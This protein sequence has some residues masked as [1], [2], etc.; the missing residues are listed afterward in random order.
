MENVRNGG[1]IGEKELLAV[2][3]GTSYA[4]NRRRTIGAIEEA[5]EQAFS[6]WSIRRAFTSK[7]I[8]ARIR[9]MENLSIDYLEEA[10]ERAKENG[11]KQ[12][13]LQ[14]T[15]MM[16]GIEY[17]ELLEKVRKEQQAFERLTVGRPLLDQ[18]TDFRQLVQILTEQTRKYADKKTAICFMGH[19]TASK[20]NRVYETLQNMFTDCGYHNYLVGTVE[21][22]PNLTQLRQKVKEQG[23]DRVILQPLMIVAGDH[24]NHDMAG[25]NEDSWKSAFKSDG[26]EVVCILKGLGEIPEVQNMFVTHAKRAIEE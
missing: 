11:V 22:E 15:L 17:Q 18:E 5:L 13:V 24:A 3:F 7:K 14:P 9:E 2:S 10:M 23:Y 25:D 8:I 21:A 1:G 12:L 26:C 6:D 19:G 16:D 20:A 4:Q